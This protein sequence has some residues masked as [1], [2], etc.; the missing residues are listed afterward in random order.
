MTKDEIR[1]RLHSIA[2]S[3]ERPQTEDI[4]GPNFLDQDAEARLALHGV[5]DLMLEILD[6]ERVIQES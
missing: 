2:D 3:F 6:A 4:D 1:Y 5:I